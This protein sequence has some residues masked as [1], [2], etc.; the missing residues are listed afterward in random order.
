MNGWY[1][2]LLLVLTERADLAAEA[3]LHRCYAGA[4]ASR[5]CVVVLL[6]ETRLGVRIRWAKDAGADR[7]R[8]PPRPP[9]GVSEFAWT[10]LISWEETRG[11]AVV[12][13][14]RRDAG[15]LAIAI[16][17]PNGMA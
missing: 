9:P 5:S 11:V 7:P 13:G 3:P 15:V 14:F 12:S 1:P 17:S 2:L 16:G 10:G 6:S 4:R 8:R